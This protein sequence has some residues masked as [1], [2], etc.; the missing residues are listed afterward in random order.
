MTGSKKFDMIL[1]LLST[2]VCVAAVGLL[3]YSHFILSPE[4]FSE[5]AELSN[6]ISQAKNINNTKAYTLKPLTINLYS[7]ST[8]LRYIDLAISILP[9][10]DRQTKRIKKYETLIIDTIIKEV[11]RKT[12]D[13]LN[14]ISGRIILESKLKSEINKIA[15]QKVSKELFF[16][17]FVIQ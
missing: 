13:E 17:K 12:P 8:R 11:S 6:L 3:Y 15:K 16:T 7:R 1:G 5:E 10:A 14:S 2:S 4:P 9:F